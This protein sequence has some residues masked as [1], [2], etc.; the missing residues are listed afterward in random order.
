MLDRYNLK[1]LDFEISSCEL[2]EENI[3]NKQHHNKLRPH[4]DVTRQSFGAN[5]MQVS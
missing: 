1:N 4:N 5:V 3:F 2:M